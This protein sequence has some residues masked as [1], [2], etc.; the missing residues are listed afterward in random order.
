[1]IAEELQQEDSEWYF[2]I[3]PRYMYRYNEVVLGT[4]TVLAKKS[5]HHCHGTGIACY[6]S[7]NKNL[8]TT[9]IP[10]HCKC[11]VKQEKIENEQQ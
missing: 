8:N 3:E 6:V 9:R 10:M 5:C 11:L 2:N 7:E 4:M 1:M